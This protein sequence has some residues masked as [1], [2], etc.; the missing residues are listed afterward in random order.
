LYESEEHG[1]SSPKD[2]PKELAETQRVLRIWA[3][4]APKY[5]RKIAFFERFLFDGMR[6]WA[7]SR[8]RGDVLEVGVGTARNLEHYPPDVRLTGVDLSPETLEIGRRR[9]MALG[10]EVDLRVANAESLDFPAESFDTVISTLTMCSIPNYRRA[11]GEARRVLR[12]GGSLV[13]VEH[14]RSPSVAVRAGQRLLN[15]LTVRF[16]A[17]HLLRDPLVAVRRLGMEVL[18]RERL[19]WGIVERLVARKPTP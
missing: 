4:F 15:P 17:D 6:V 1:V 3:K 8:A 7:C 13:M 9:A 11:L 12:P 19:K 2:D 10:R 16:A 14:V 5:D 18:E